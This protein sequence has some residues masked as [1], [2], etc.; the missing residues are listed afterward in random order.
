MKLSKET[1]DV[2]KNFSAINAG[3]VVSGGTEVSTMGVMKDIIAIAKIKEEL[4]P[5]AI[6]ELSRFLSAINLFKDPE[7][8]FKNRH[9]KIGEGKTFANYYYSDPSLIVSPKPIVFPAVDLEFTIDRSSFTDL[10]KAAATLQLTEISLDGN[11]DELTFSA[12]DAKNSTENS[13]SLGVEQFEFEQPA[14]STNF[15]FKVDKLSKLLPGSYTVSVSNR[16]IS[17]W[18]NKEIDLTYYV[19]VERESEGIKHE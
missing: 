5:F 19:A 6:Y 13:Y 18:V 16:L 3:I 14:T 15:V 17:R 2:L 1:I 7:L 12:I 11:S 9:V 4:P 10:I 8:E